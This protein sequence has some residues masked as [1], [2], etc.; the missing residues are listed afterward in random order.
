MGLLTGSARASGATD[1]R[2]VHARCPIC[3]DDAPWDGY[4]VMLDLDLSPIQD[5]L[6]EAG[7]AVNLPPIL[8]VVG[9]ST[10][11]EAPSE[12]EGAGSATSSS[13]DQGDAR[14]SDGEAAPAGTTWAR[15]IPMEDVMEHDQ[16][17]PGAWV[18]LDP[19]HEATRHVMSVGRKR[20]VVNVSNAVRVC[21]SERSLLGHKQGGRT[22]PFEHG[23]VWVPEWTNVPDI[24]TKSGDQLRPPEELGDTYDLF[25]GYRV[26][27]REPVHHTSLTFGEGPEILLVPVLGDSQAGKSSWILSLASAQAPPAPIEIGNVKVKFGVAELPPSLTRMAEILQMNKA[28]RDAFFSNYYFGTDSSS[29]AHLLLDVEIVGRKTRRVRLLLADFA[30]EALKQGRFS[31]K[32]QIMEAS[33]SHASGLV[34]LRTAADLLAEDAINDGHQ[35]GD[36]VVVPGAIQLLEAE[37]EQRR[38]PAVYAF[39]QTDRLLSSG[40]MVPL[41]QGMPRMR[42]E[43]PDLDFGDAEAGDASLDDPKGVSRRVQDY[44]RRAA[45]EPEDLQRVDRNIGNRYRYGAFHAASRD[46]SAAETIDRCTQAAGS[47]A[48][49]SLMDGDFDAM[50]ANDH[51]GPVSAHACSSRTSVGIYEPLLALLHHMDLLR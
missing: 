10:G 41:I 36:G 25:P 6:A 35:T 4:W 29:G 15:G 51:I 31:W 32:E 9:S 16:K 5:L 46:L 23:D 40:T 48:L 24:M 49:A 2:G 3:L 28:V 50:A 13:T 7:V 21:P 19:A 44:M 42:R 8:E 18:L 33:L 34:F 14:A 26:D 20:K 11:S 1:T 47:L 17:Q 45:S 43:S 22:A 12:P 37:P 39:S 38:I 27:P 30:G